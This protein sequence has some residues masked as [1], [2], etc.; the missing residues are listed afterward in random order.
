MLGRRRQFQSSLNLAIDL[1][2]VVACWLVAYP[3][4]FQSGL[5]ALRVPHVPAFSTYAWIGALVALIWAVVFRANL[6]NLEK[7]VPSL[8]RE[9][10]FV[11][12]AHAISFLVFVVV[13]FFLAQYKPSRIVFG[14]FFVLST[15]TL[16]ATHVLFRR[17]LIARYRR[18][19]GVRRALIVGTGELGRGLASRLL[20]HRELGLEIIGF[21]SD[22][23]PMPERV[24]DRPVYGAPE[25]VAHVVR[26][27]RIELVLVALPLFAADRLRK[28]L[29]ALDEELVDVKVVPDLYQYVT[30]RAAVE[31]FEGLPI[32]SLRDT[33]MHGWNAL[34]KRAFDLVATSIGLVVLSPLLLGLA[35]LVK[36]TSRGPVFY[37][38]ERMGLDGRTF[39]ILKFRS[40]RTDAE[41]ATGAVWAV[42]DDPRRTRI[43]TFMR[44]TN[45]DELPQLLNVLAG[46]MSLVGPRPERPVF[47]EQFRTQIPKY[48]L[49][50]RVKAG[51]T[52]WAQANGWRGNT[53][54][55]RRIEC[56]IYYIENWSLWLDI[57][58][59]WM[60]LARG[61][62]DKNA[63]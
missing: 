23:A 1:V 57:R 10:A 47:I 14:L 20:D 44:R 62:V 51:I 55:R 35:A 53:D 59:I 46:H 5:I 29:E 45:L 50:H 16:I 58:I 31:E 21:L 37:A 4:R 8:F 33:P 30:L 9:V 43:G 32:V 6:A 49:R 36:L 42:K 22:D 3:I 40:M 63:Y 61:F 19:I 52:G 48:M 41:S 27:E 34:V 17:A 54:L 15:A 12:R 60:T 2:V 11:L 18:G 24:L 25:D 28:V 56:D 38:Q 39:R 13:T 7:T 26:A